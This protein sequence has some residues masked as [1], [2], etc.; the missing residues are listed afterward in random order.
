M[1]ERD[2]L[3]K[4]GWFNSAIGYEAERSKQQ[5]KENEKYLAEINARRENEKREY[6]SKLR[7]KIPISRKNQVLVK[8]NTDGWEDVDPNVGSNLAE[9]FMQN[10]EEVDNESKSKISN[11]LSRKSSFNLHHHGE[12]SLSVISSKNSS[13]EDQESEIDNKKTIVQ[14]MREKFNN[15]NM[16]QVEMQG[17]IL[18][19]PIKDIEKMVGRESWQFLKA[20]GES[21]LRWHLYYQIPKDMPRRK[22]IFAGYGY[23]NSNK[24]VI[25]R[26]DGKSPSNQSKIKSTNHTYNVQRKRKPIFPPKE[27]KYG[28]IKERKSWCERIFG[29]CFRDDSVQR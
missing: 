26:P 11:L 2:V 24:S 14:L 15:P 13:I 19:M 25:Y 9:R 28:T 8:K 27:I 17:K 20:L 3:K 4:L 22:K 16:S 12:D 6:E 7:K 5:K 18:E 10:N 21:E 29:S 1:K 23:Q